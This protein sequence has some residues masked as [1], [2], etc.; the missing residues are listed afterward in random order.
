MKNT[1]A[2]RWSRFNRD[3]RSDFFFAAFFVSIRRLS[4]LFGGA[5]TKK[6]RH[7]WSKHFSLNKVV[8]IKSHEW[9]I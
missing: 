1:A 5:K 8:H 4:R 7:I 2:V 3:V 6:E 9:D